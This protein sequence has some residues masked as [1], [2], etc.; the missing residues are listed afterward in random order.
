MGL[1]ASTSVGSAG[2]RVGV[3]TGGGGGGGGLFGLLLFLGA[4][5]AAVEY[6]YVLVGLIVLVALV[7]VLI[8]AIQVEREKVEPPPPTNWMKGPPYP[9]MSKE[10]N[11]AVNRYLEDRTGRITGLDLD[12]EEAD[13]RK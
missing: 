11:V 13:W 5:Y 9:D 12:D 10:W 7:L 8:A 2:S 6:W 3:S 4:I 1:F